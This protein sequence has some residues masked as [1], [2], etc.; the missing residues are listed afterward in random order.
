MEEMIRDEVVEMLSTLKEDGSN[1]Q[2]DKFIAPAVLNVLWTLATGARISR[3]NNQLNELLD[4]FSV[5]SK[6]FDMTG[7]TLTQYPWLRFIA[8][9]WCGY[10]LI[11]EIN[12]KLKNFFV[13]TIEEHQEM[14]QEGRNDDLIYRYISEIKTPNKNS[15]VFNGNQHYF[16]S[17]LKIKP[18]YYFS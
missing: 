16:L 15:E 7:G 4:L 12:K 13:K 14:W 6:A 18:F 17:L 8:P 9:E 11:Q 2:V 3:K 1:V 10:N 5:R